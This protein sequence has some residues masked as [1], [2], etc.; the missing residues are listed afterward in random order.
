VITH[1]VVQ[2][3][4]L[5]AHDNVDGSHPRTRSQ[6]GRDPQAVHVISRVLQMVISAHIERD[7]AR[8]TNCSWERVTILKKRCTL[9][10]SRPVRQR[11]AGKGI[12]IDGG[13]SL[14]RLDREKLI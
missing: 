1:V 5:S 10:Q 6:H 14:S 2:H 13:L 7:C 12:S 11:H 3:L 8:A 4:S 9:R